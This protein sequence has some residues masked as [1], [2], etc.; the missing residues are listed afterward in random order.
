M[1]KENKSVEAIQ[2]KAEV[3]EALNADF[4]DWKMSVVTL[5]STDIDDTMNTVMSGISEGVR[6]KTALNIC[7]VTRSRF[8]TWLEDPDHRT[9]FRRSMSFNKAY[10]EVIRF[11]QAQGNQE[12]RDKVLKDMDGDDDYMD[13]QE[14]ESNTKDG[15]NLDAPKPWTVLAKK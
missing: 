8:K 9:D 5:K 1:S 7:G 4:K 2:K 6:P 12:L 15:N 10:L 14:D 13:V 11:K 3:I